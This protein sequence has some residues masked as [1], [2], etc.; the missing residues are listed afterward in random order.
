MKALLMHRE[1]DFQTMEALPWNEEALTQDL[2]LG[3]LVKAMAGDDDFLAE[4]ARRA[5]L[6]GLRNDAETI[7]YRQ[8]ILKDAQKNPEAVRELYRLTEEAIEGVKKH[9]WGLTSRYPSS[10]LYSAL[11]LLEFHVEMLR[12]VRGLAER[13]G[14]RFESAGFTRL[15]AMLRDELGD[16]YLARVET[17]LEELK[18][19]KGVLL[20]AEL[21]KGNEGI[22]YMLRRARG[23]RPNWIQRVLG[24][25]PRSYTFSLAERDQTGGQILTDMR[26]EGIS[27]VARALAESAGHVLNFFKMLR[28]ELAFYVGCLNLEERLRAKGEPMCFPIPATAGEGRHRF[29]GL[30]DVCLSLHMKERVT[31]NEAE[32]DGK[33]LVIVT[34]AN[35]GGKSSFLRSIG[36]AQMMMQSGMFAG[37]ERY[38]AGV[39]S[40]LITHYKREEDA[41]MKSGKF[42][43]EMA[44]MSEIAGHI[45]PNAM[46]LLN[47]SFA[48]TNEREGSEIARQIVGAL[49][50]KGMRI[51][52]VTHLYE[53][54]RGYFEG[55]RENTLF[56]RA[57]R[58]A[59]GTRT[60]RMLEGEP[61]ET[62]YGVDLY[63]QIFEAS[64]GA[65]DGGTG[66]ESVST[67]ADE[68]REG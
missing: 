26:H 27:R 6:C 8:E 29:R 39:C 50:E 16:E 57:E 58:K 22:N 28:A 19:R 46:V 11:D 17:H 15:F 65:R 30:Y 56:L 48:A 33:R 55:R 49:V 7:L 51:F 24:K 32:A 25:G 42:D 59:D 63:R 36:Q 52:Y 4:V 66:V 2:E 68:R 21:G 67:L 61:L 10:L 38:E 14:G 34:G 20:S 5:L 13:M 64:E 37:A 47:E 41:T 45:R 53:F 35:Q 31:G 23:K 18:F 3:T 60:F 43:E 62:S 12:K 1:R 9:W 40:G 54:A 44:R